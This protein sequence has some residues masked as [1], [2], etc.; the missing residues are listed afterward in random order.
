MKIR[1]VKSSSKP[2]WT[3]MYP[4]PLSW[5]RDRVYGPLFGTR[6]EAEKYLAERS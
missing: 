4:S 3:I 6:A 1:I 2:F 5:R